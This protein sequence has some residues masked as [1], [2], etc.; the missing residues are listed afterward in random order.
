MDKIIVNKKLDSLSRCINRIQEKCPTDASELKTNLDLQDVIVLNL[1]RAVQ[2]C[3]D[4]AAHT[5]AAS[6]QPVPNTMSEAFQSLEEMQIINTHLAD[7]LK[8]SVGFRNL[9]VH[10]YHD[11]NWDI[12]FAVASKHLEDFKQFARNISANTGS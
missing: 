6:N 10:N 2:L 12:V 5:L 8:K 3:V 9:A 1:S 11:L 7:R 4:I